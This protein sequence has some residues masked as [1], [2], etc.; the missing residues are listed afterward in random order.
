MGA[1]VV[2]RTRLVQAAKSGGRRCTGAARPR[3]TAGLEDQVVDPHMKDSSS[4]PR[5][6]DE[7]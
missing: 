3:I 7:S 2:M 1:V 4:A 6:W 5:L